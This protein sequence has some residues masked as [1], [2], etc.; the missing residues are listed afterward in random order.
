MVPVRATS[1]REQD[2]DRGDHTDRHQHR[3]HELTVRPLVVSPADASTVGERGT[4]AG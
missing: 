3:A 1:G 4:S 2:R